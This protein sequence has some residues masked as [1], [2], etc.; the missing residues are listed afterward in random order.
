M[1]YFTY[2]NMTPYQDELSTDEWEE[3]I[4]VRESRAEDILNDL[5]CE[6]EYE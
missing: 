2:E 1:N 5:E 3:L 4:A 6:K